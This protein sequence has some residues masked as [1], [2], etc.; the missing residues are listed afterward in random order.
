MFPLI[1]L[2]RMLTKILEMDSAI[3]PGCDL[4]IIIKPCKGKVRIEN[5]IE[6]RD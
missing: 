2:A 1:I 6:N 4:G 3:E 5:R